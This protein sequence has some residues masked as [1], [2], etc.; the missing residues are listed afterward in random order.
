MANTTSDK[1]ENAQTI[2]RSARVVSIQRAET[3]AT[4]N[5]FFYV[6]RF[7][8]LSLSLYLSP[9]AQQWK[10]RWCVMRKL[11]P[12]AG[13]C[14]ALSPRVYS[15][16][17]VSRVPMRSGTNQQHTQKN[18]ISHTQTF[19]SFLVRIRPVN[20]GVHSEIIIRFEY[21]ASDASLP[22]TRRDHRTIFRA[23]FH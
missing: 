15:L 9:C 14:Q 10:S 20:C 3:G 22:H 4:I 8:F 1:Y 6:F 23:I 11:S 17:R 16:A 12:V 7:E 18:I 21:F 5:I 2:P 13:K 19:L